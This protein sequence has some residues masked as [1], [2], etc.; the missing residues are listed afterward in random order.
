MSRRLHPLEILLFDT[1]I[2]YILKL[3]LFKNCAKSDKIEDSFGPK[4]F[5]VNFNLLIQFNTQ[6]HLGYAY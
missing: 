1:L 6:Q 3:H 4:F 2:V 5:V